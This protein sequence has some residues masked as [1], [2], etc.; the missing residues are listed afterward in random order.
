MQPRPVPSRWIRWRRR[1][2]RALRAAL[3]GGFLLVLAA[4]FTSRVIPLPPAL[5]QPPDTTLTLEDRNGREIAVV[6]S[7][8]AR[9]AEA[10]TLGEMGPWL[11]AVTVGL[12]DR[13]FWRH[14]GMDAWALGGAACR[15]L[16]TLRVVSGGSTIAQQLIKNTRPRTG[17][18]WYDKGYEALAAWRLTRTWPRERILEEYLN[19]IDYGN[20]RVGP[21]AAAR[22]YFGKEPADLTVAEAVYL[23][24]LPQSPT[25][26]NP[27]LRPR[28]AAER[29]RRSL[30][31]LAQRGVL[32]AATL[33]ALGDEPPAVRRR[34]VPNAAPHF[35][36]A[37]VARWPGRRGRVRTTLD[38][39]LQQAVATLVGDHVRRLGARGVGQAA[40]V[41]LDNRSGAVLAMVGSADYAGPEGENNGVLTPRS[42]GSVLKPF[43]YVEA[44]ERKLLT[45]ASVLPDTPDAIRA[46][47][48]DYD[49][50]NFDERYLGPVRV[51]EALASSLNV[52]AVYALSRV[53]ART[54][55][56]KLQSWGFSF[57][58]GLHEYGAGLIL[59]NAEPRL[60]DLA[61]AFAG[62]A[63][64]GRVPHW[65][66][67]ADEPVRGRVVATPEATAIVAD[68]L[69]DDDARRRAFG[70]GSP[71]ATPVRVPCKT[72]TSSAFR[73]AWTVGSTAQHTVAVWA[74]NFDG[75]PMAGTA[76]IEAAAPLWR[77]V[78]DELLQTD[79]GVPAPAG[80]SDCEV[81]R[82]TGRRPT[83]DSPGVVREWFLPSTEP[84]EIAA[85]WLRTEGGR[86]ILTL[87][88]EYAAWCASAQNHLG[89][90]VESERKLT[91]RR[92]EEGSEYVIDP[93]LP[94][95]Q[96]MV[97]LEAML[98]P[99]AEPVWTV[100]GRRVPAQEGGAILWPLEPGDF[101]AV[102]VAADLRAEV[103]F[104]VRR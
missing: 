67:L 34:V 90:V 17:W 47:Y 32:D 96:Q 88:Q 75:R 87:P 53:G 83:G 19:R 24:G 41:V 14:N 45:A 5:L 22:A 69:C 57:P 49:P 4:D 31:V 60:I 6:A 55:F 66:L 8:R 18:R 93:T 68:I 63:A 44:I 10:V 28:Q 21:R 48:V 26:F 33:G 100:N 64:E 70:R 94:Q 52:P 95:A 82:L 65:R 103:R 3:I 37:V 35:V 104:R 62:I 43:L 36:D 91:I 51:R 39:P 85:E 56:E 101:C 25:R 71:L 2:G 29:Y 74:G 79:T 98:P 80:L 15:N 102:V 99:G 40:V 38:L 23:A 30:A 46:E 12:E 42:G 9:Q 20:R 13:N 84:T 61:A 7:R 58:R 50:Q 97:P 89:A 81:C 78:V 86:T 92:P 54:F 76:S 27:W 73:D 16:R 72:G 77:A 11:P 59:G 1:A